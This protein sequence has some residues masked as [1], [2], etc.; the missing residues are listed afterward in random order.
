MRILPAFTQD[1]MDDFY[2]HIDVLLFPSQWKESFGLTVREALVRNIWIIS[3]DGGGTT[4]DL[5][6]GENATII[7]ISS[8][9]QHLMKAIF[10]CLDKDFSDYENPYVEDIITYQKQAEQLYNFYTANFELE[11]QS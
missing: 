6:D 11:A 8:N 5:V 1:T 4:E 9:I 2:K 7:P 10:Q 3:T